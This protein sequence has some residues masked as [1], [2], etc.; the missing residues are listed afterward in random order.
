MLDEARRANGTVY[1][2]IRFTLNERSDLSLFEDGHFDFIYSNIVLQ[3][4]PREL[5]AG[6]VR[7]FARVLAPGGV[8]VF[9]T[10][11]GLDYRRPTAFLIAVLPTPLL[12]MLRRARHGRDG[13][14]EM[15]CLPTEEVKA[16][17]GTHGVEIIATDRDQAAGPAFL[18]YR[19]IARRA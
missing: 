2:N 15:H 18:S 14:M 11:A 8:L 1:P 16:A 17:L 9:Q 19:Y 12:N 10:P 7:E 6:F 3:H 13:V 5:Q 4:I